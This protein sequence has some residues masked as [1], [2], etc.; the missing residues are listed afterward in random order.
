MGN[1]AIET[2][3]EQPMQRLIESL[4]AMHGVDL[5]QTGVSLTL[6]RPGQSGSL[7]LYNAG[8]DHV[9]LACLVRAPDGQL[10]P[11]V[12]FLYF[13]DNSAGWKLVEIRYSPAAWAAYM[14]SAGTSGAHSDSTDNDE[15]MLNGFVTYWAGRLAEEGWLT[16]GQACVRI[17]GCQSTNHDHCY[18]ELW[19]CSACHRTFCCAEGTDNHPELCDDCWAARFA[20]VGEG[21][22]SGVTFTEE[23]TLELLCACP[24]ACGTWLELTAD[25]V[26]ALE[27]KDGLRVSLLLPV[28]LEDAIRQAAAIQQAV[29][30]K[31]HQETLND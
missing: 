23:D 3:P 16:D 25:G 5:C 4:T 7:L 24:E 31:I 15:A 6:I 2:Q 30:P 20:A 26:L 29:Q 21:D 18:G 27:D 22:M 13:N 19:Q 12:E 10:L 17:S 28:W 14:A 11:E 8:V 1:Q 9:V